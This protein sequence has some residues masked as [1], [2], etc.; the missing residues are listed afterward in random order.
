MDLEPPKPE[1]KKRTPKMQALNE[2]LFLQLSPRVWKDCK[3]P[4]AY[5]KITTTWLRSLLQHYSLGGRP[6]P[7]S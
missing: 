3:A 1:Y 6:P 7:S 2:A 4:E 5:F